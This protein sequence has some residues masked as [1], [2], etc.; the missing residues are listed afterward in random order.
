MA[1]KSFKKEIQTGVDSLITSTAENK[2]LREKESEYVGIHFQAPKELKKEINM[3][4]A[5]AGL[6]KKDFLISVI[7]EYLKNN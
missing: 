1:K 7:S 2:E 3:Y 6:P 4:C 5:N